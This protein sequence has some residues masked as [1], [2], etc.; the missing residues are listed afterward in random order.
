ML[1]DGINKY[2]DSNTKQGFINNVID[3]KNTTT[4]VNNDNKTTTS[5]KTKKA[6]PIIVHENNNGAMKLAEAGM[7]SNHT[8]GAHIVEKNEG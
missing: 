2:N 5:N 1:N 6:E 8:L 3:D 7:E 4:V